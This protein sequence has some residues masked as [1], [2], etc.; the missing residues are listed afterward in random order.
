MG[1][2]ARRLA[3]ALAV[4]GGVGA[5]APGAATATA[6]GDNGLIAVV[7]DGDIWTVSADG[8]GAAPLI[9]TPADESAP[10]WSP[11]GRRLAFARDGA[12]WVARSDGTGQRIVVDDPG[13]PEGHP[14]WSPDGERIAFARAEAGWRWHR[15]WRL[16]RL[17]SVQ[18]DGT[19]ERAL[20]RAD[21][22]IAGDPDWH[23]GGDGIAFTCRLGRGRRAAWVC[24]AGVA[25]AAL[26]GAFGPPGAVLGPGASPS[27]SPDG[28]ALAVRIPPR[29]EVAGGIAV[30][31][32][33]STAVIHP[34]PARQPAFSPDGA[35]IAFVRGDRRAG[36]GELWVMGADGAGARR[37][38]GR[39]TAPDWQ[40]LAP[41]PGEPE[42]PVPPDPEPPTEPEPDPGPQ[43]APT[44]P[45][46]T[47]P[48]AAPVPPA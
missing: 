25:G 44:P 34:G 6:P 12:I 18:L 30:I 5:L 20:T 15:G 40:P 14:S 7:R 29:D 33:G 17:W 1:G 31:A 47:A 8:T 27:W 32:G 3:A 28:R 43:P 45:G 9:A 38:L 21:R 42:P 10:A 4:A 39:A 35:M 36:T 37:V 24:G 23:P 26:D 16:V 22:A 19:G 11:D 41:P 48:E 46:E 2:R 13:R